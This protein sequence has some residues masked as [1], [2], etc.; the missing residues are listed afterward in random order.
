MQKIGYLITTK[1]RDKL[2]GGWTIRIGNGKGEEQDKTLINYV[3]VLIQTEYRKE[4]SETN[5]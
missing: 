5:K 2:V 3:D 4:N 1:G